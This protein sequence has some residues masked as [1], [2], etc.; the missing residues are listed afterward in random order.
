MTSGAGS[1]TL[2]VEG[3]GSRRDDH[4]AVVGP[5]SRPRRPRGRSR[6]RRRES[7][8]MA[9]NAEFNARVPP[10]SPCNSP[11]SPGPRRARRLSEASLGNQAASRPSM[12]GRSSH[13]PPRRSPSQLR[14]T[15]LRDAL[16][17]FHDLRATGITWLAIR[18]DAPQAIQARAGHTDYATTLG[19][20]LEAE[21]IRTGFGDVFPPLPS[22]L[23]KPAKPRSQTGNRGARLDIGPGV[24]V[25]SSQAV[26]ITQKLRGGRDSNPRGGRDFGGRVEQ[27]T[28]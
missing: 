21:S 27:R 3:P 9:L 18:G 28:G 20:I 1:M 7:A 23:L 10:H 15:R 13:S 2:G 25:Q 16:I 11:H 8:W 12:G 4:E 14:S 6:G 22:A 19:C 26:A 17:T 5:R 24:L